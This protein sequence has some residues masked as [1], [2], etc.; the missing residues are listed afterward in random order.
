MNVVNRAINI[1]TKPRT[2]WAVIAAEPAT[3]GGLF[4]GYA[5]ILAALPAIGSLLGTFLFYGAYPGLVTFAIATALVAYL[6]GLGVVYLMG[7]IVA[8]LAP[9]FGGANDQVPAMKMVVYAATPVW[10]IGF[11]AQLVMPMNFGLGMLVMLAAYG[12]AA[13]QLYLA[14]T[15]VVKVAPDK[16]VGFTI[17]TIVIWF[18]VAMVVTMIIGGIVLSAVGIGAVTSAGYNMR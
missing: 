2:E 11:L 7:I 1:L 15:S 13:Y 17:V 6:V 3:V 12:Y 8:A 10:V 9:S 18:I 5:M 14:S 16:A 4:T